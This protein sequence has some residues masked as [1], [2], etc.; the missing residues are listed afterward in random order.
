MI[1]VDRTILTRTLS[2]GRGNANT[3]IVAS[4]ANQQLM[5]DVAVEVLSLTKV[6]SATVE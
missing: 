3:N 1:F 6:T 4:V 5:A 2:V